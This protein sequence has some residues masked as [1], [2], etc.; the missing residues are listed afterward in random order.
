MLHTR[1]ELLLPFEYVGDIRR[2]GL[3]GHVVIREELEA[4]VGGVCVRLAVVPVPVPCPVRCDG[5][6]PCPLRSVEQARGRVVVLVVVGVRVVVRVT[7][8]LVV[9]VLV[10]SALGGRRSGGLVT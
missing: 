2:G 3:G 10:T 7:P 6:L 4:H 5:T 9:T 8:A 1:H